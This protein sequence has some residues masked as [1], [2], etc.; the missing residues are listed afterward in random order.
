MGLRSPPRAGAHSSVALN[1]RR[2]LIN[3][4]VK[5]FSSFFFTH[6]GD[7]KGEGGGPSIAQIK[8]SFSKMYIL[9]LYL[10]CSSPQ[11][12]ISFTPRR[13]QSTY[14]TVF[15]TWKESGGPEGGHGGSTRKYRG[16]AG[17]GSTMLPPAP[18]CSQ[19]ALWVFF[20][21]T[22]RRWFL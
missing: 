5:L 20:M 9:D 17:S 22:I 21:P 13:S 8:V 14:W 18:S 19:S 1:S 16:K 3:A 11:S 10:G 15:G 7:S 12:N 6:G 4:S 2:I